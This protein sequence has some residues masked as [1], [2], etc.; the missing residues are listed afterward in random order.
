MDGTTA[1]K[2]IDPQAVEM[3]EQN[4]LSKKAEAGEILEHGTPDQMFSNP[5]EE[6]T[7]A[8]LQRVIEAGRLIGDR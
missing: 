6:R 1:G 4:M 2:A 5:R 8:F 7:K 3:A